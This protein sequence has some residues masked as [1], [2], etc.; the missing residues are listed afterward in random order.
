M[1]KFAY[2]LKIVHKLCPL[3]DMRLNKLKACDKYC[4][5]KT[6]NG[7]RPISIRQKSLS[8]SKNQFYAQSLSLIY[9]MDFHLKIRAIHRVFIFKLMIRNF[10]FLFKIL[11]LR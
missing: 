2:V 4:D 8:Y 6:Y 7:F 5:I 3:Y 11:D 1:A 10:K 9:G